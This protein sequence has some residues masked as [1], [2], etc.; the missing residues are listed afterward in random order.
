MPD[1]NNGFKLDAKEFEGYTR[2]T[3]EHIKAQLV[4]I[5][6]KVEKF[7]KCVTGLKVKMATIG[8]VVSLLVTIMT[9]LIKEMIAK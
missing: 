8:G 2:A 5:D 7:E 3:L 4:S 6:A 9:L 1:Q